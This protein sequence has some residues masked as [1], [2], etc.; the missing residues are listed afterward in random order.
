MDPADR[1]ALAMDTTPQ[2]LHNDHSQLD[3]A[4]Q[5]DSQRVRYS[6]WRILTIVL[7][8]TGYAGYYL[9]RSD[10]SVVLPMLSA[11]LVHKGIP[12]NI[13][14]IR[15]GTITSL[16]VFAY[17]LGKFPTGWLADRFGGRLNFL[18]GMAGSILFTIAFALSG[19][20]PL[21]TLAW[22][23]NRMVQALGWNSIVKISS[24]WFSYS[25]YGTVMGI[26]SLSYLLGDAAS[27]EFMSL[28]IAAGLGWR[29]VF[30]VAG[31]ML[32]VLLLLNFLLLKDSPE[33]IGC[34]EPQS[35]PENLFRSADERQM[36]PDF[37]SLVKTFARNGTFWLVC[38][39]SIGVTILRETF[40]LWTPTYFTQSIGLSIAD[41]AQKSALFP[42]F[43]AFSVVAAG[44]L[45]DRLGKAGRAIIIFY[46]MLLAAVVL[47][48]LA[49]GHLGSS[50][51]VPV[52][53]VALVALVM[54]GPYS[55]LSGAISLDF[56]GK[57][58]SGS[59]S[60]FIDG[61]GY[62]G[63]IL[64]GN[65][66]ARVSVTWGWQGVFALLTLV[67]LLSAV[68]AGI[69]LKRQM[70]V[71]EVDAQIAKIAS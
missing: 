14:Q 54:M 61:T 63:G 24:R 66:V 59:A 27:R 44:F 52:T 49:W 21:F 10:L 20:F 33:N 15:L 17:A 69:Y 31:A 16:G 36:A 53:L 70:R 34:P 13:V 38:I 22:M 55:Y 60:G 48:V 62:L 9:C 71:G 47:S 8:V 5:L 65:C 6:F 3:S 26:M 67:A 45:S 68:A 23:S 1:L 58:G 40:N 28:L 64:A 46:G 51:L 43:G 12:P 41:A 7:M 30:F 4:H 56:G 19:G 11:E 25:A 2:T 32:S 37:R 57:H 35:N 50:K 29:S 18:C 39:L 42:L